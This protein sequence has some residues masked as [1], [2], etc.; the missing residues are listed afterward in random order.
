MH[1]FIDTEFTDLKEPYLVAAALVAE[2]GRELYFEL[3]GITGAVCS[4]FVR[5]TVLPLLGGPVVQPIEAAR[6]VAAFLSNYELVTFFTDAPRYNIQLL[7]PFLP[8]KLAWTVAVPSFETEEAEIAFQILYMQA[9][10][11]EGLRRH[12]ALDDARALRC[13]WLN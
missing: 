7:E 12:H 8:Q 6:Q 1:I 13:A 10:V 11:K 9:F 4:S 3:D 2:D 5:E